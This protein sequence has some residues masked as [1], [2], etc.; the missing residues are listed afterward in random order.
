M[1]DDNEVRK[2]VRKEAER[3]L[4]EARKSSKDLRVTYDIEAEFAKTRK[5]RSY[6]V[7]L[8]T[9]GTIAALALLAWGATSWISKANE[10]APVDVG[11]F[12]DLNLKDLLDT[13]KRNEGD[14]KRVEA[15]IASMRKDL[16]LALD[17][18]DREYGMEV[19]S[20]RARSRTAAEELAQVEAARVAWLS[21][22]REIQSS[23]GSRI[24]TAERTAREIQARIDKY[25]QRL[26]EQ[27]RQQ[28]AILDNAQKVFEIE[29]QK[30]TAGYEARL[31]ALEA[32]R[33]RDLAT[34]ARQREELAAS[35]TSRFNPV[36]DDARSKE[37]LQGWKAP[38]YGPF[39]PLAPA[40]FQGGFTSE[41]E[42]AG[43]ERSL[44]DL[45]YLAERL[46]AVPYLNSVPA[47]LSR[48][49]G[50]ALAS[51]AAYR[52]L[53]DRV[54]AGIVDRD[55]LIAERDRLIADRER[56]IAERDRFITGLEAMVRSVESERDSLD[57]AIGRYALG[58]RETGFIIDPRDP[59]KITI[60]L[61][62]EIPVADGSQALVVR[63][64]KTIARIR[65]AASGRRFIASIQEIAE[66]ESVLPFDGVL[67]LAGTGAQ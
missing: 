54:A 62:P 17:A 3:F 64:E 25:D 1:G 55:L 20:I 59:A 22:K 10:S 12:E 37:L 2:L 23:Y 29:K 27:A 16:S 13:A 51:I 28:Q 65:I 8:V 47:A 46:R 31:A 61:N 45:R 53:S 19:E 35:L 4:V 67:A 52:A 56:L 18:A 14:M 38:A 44:S 48:L 36:F 49:E 5:N 34:A 24:A 41:A 7:L 42:S 58:Q 33:K 60:A 21:R 57:W 63:G 40:L 9:F 32:A 43:L 11:A 39:A 26:M 50:E 15:E 66:G 30:L 6:G